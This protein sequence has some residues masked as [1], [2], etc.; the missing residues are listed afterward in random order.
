MTTAPVRGLILRLAVPTVASMLVTAVYNLATTFYVG[1]LST[2]ATAA[3]GVSFAAMALIQA[4]GFFFGHGSGNALS[5][6]LGARRQDKAETMAA[7]GF[8][9]A[10]G[11]GVLIAL[12]GVWQ[13]PALCRLLGSTP[14]VQPYAEE[15]LGTI[16]L[17]APVMTSALALNNQ[18]RF[19]GN[20]LL[21]MAGIVS[22]ALLNIALQPLFIFTLG[23]GLRGAAV[24]TVMCQAVSLAI[25][26]ILNM[27]RGSV[28]IRAACLSLTRPVLAEIARGGLPSL[29]RQGLACLATLLLNVAAGQYGDA[30]IAGMSITT[31]VTFLIYAVFLGLGQGYQPVCGYCYGARRYDRVLAGFRFCTVYGTLGMVVCAVAGFVW[32]EPFTALFRD[33]ADVIAVGATALRWQL[34]AYP[35]N[36]FVTVCNM[37]LQTIGRARPATILASARQGIFFIPLI[38]VLPP[39]L[40]LAGVQ[41]ATPIADACSFALA[42][43]LVRGTLRELRNA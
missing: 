1:R 2:Q 25:L 15:Y 28:P 27:R 21:G 34:L 7:T 29:A 17:G 24:C 33:D 19:Q 42:F 22:G 20:A 5:R 31:R 39:L 37:T 23:W 41:L 35:L 4:A 6:H 30:A 3:V 26:Y 40:G 36:M 43:P 12:A 11:F 13:L 32:A 10:L 16:L 14:T 18:L 9:T 8:F 38:L